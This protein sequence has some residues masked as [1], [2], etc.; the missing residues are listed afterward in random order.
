MESERYKR[1]I[2]AITKADQ[3]SLKEK[4]VAVVGCGGLGGFVIEALARLGVGSLRLIDADSFSESNLNR[5]LY[6]TKKNIGKSKAKAAKKRIRKINS[7]VKA[8]AFE[9]LITKENATE[10]LSGCDLCIDALDNIEGR[11]IL[12]DACSEL[13]IYLIHG[14]IEGWNAQISCVAPGSGTI[15]KLYG[16]VDLNEKQP[17][18]SVLSFTAEF[19]ASLEAAEAVKVLT[20]YG[21]KLENRLLIADLKIGDFEYVQI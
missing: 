7:D 1:N 16:Q 20:G 4:S 14:A 13:G 10:F 5:Q 21:E 11:L 17:A 12:E 3:E 8:E 9:E 2:P 19:A 15:K 18:P 6:A